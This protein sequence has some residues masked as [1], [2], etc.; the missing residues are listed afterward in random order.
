MIYIVP[1]K[2]EH[3]EGLIANMREHDRFEYEVAGQPPSM[4][5][6]T[7]LEKSIDAW[8]GFVDQDVACMW[9]INEES[10][11]T[12]A[13]I[14]LVTTPLV[15]KRPYKFLIESRRVV[16]KA[17]NLYQYLYG[18]VD[19]QYEMSARWMEWL[20]FEPVSLHDLGKMRVYRYEMRAAH[21]D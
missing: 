11:M 16:K 5:I 18:Y 21:G 15:E 3:I 17:I 14:W 1:A 20:G 19:T 8:T 10:L 4:A 7:T 12:G 2:S 13:H 9:G 6:R